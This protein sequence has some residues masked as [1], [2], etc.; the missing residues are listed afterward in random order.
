MNL[1]FLQ[2][3][4]F[5]HMTGRPLQKVCKKLMKTQK[6]CKYQLILKNKILSFAR[7]LT[8]SSISTLGNVP[9]YPACVEV[10]YTTRTLSSRYPSSS[11]TSKK[12]VNRPKSK[13]APRADENWELRNS[14]SQLSQK[15]KVLYFTRLDFRWI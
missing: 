5:Q 7:F 2:K 12:F 10:A 13:I 9:I 8:L 14:E 11:T 3:N 15:N 4:V 6:F 1:N